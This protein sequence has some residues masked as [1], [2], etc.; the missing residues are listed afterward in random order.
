M[1]TAKDITDALIEKAKRMK[2]FE[3]TINVKPGW[4]PQGIVPFDMHI[5]DGVAIMKVIA[6][7]HEDADRQVSTYMEQYEQD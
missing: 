1:T 4:F 5:K 7:T 2:E 3:V 6:E